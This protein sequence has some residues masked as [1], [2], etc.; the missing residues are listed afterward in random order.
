M[1]FLKKSTR[2]FQI[3]LEH[4][5]LVYE[6]NASASA[7]VFSIAYQNILLFMLGCGFSNSLELHKWNGLSS[8][9]Y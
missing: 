4:I 7:F 6:T 2:N 8:F 5:I 9:F 1:S 3:K